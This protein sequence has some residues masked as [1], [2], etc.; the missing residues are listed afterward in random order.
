M[1]RSLEGVLALN[2]CF[3]VSGLA[4]LWAIRGW[5]SWLELL[6]LLGVAFLL[7][8]GSIAVLATLVLVA[9]GGLSLAVIL[10]LCGGVAAICA[11]LAVWRR[12][13]FP[14]SFGALPRSL[15]LGAFLALLAALATAVLLVAF[16]RVTRVQ[17]LTAWD[18][19]AFW[20][21]KAKAIYFFGGLDE[22]LFRSLP[23]PSYPL[24][25]PA[26]DAM[27][28]RLMGGTADTSGL[29]VQYWLLFAG[30]L[31]AA[32]ALLRPLAR[33][34]LVWLFLG[35]ATVIP[36]LDGRLL[37][38]LADWPLDIF[39]VLAALFLVRW[40]RTGEHWLIVGYGVMLAATFATKRE[41]ALLAACLVPAALAAT[42]RDRRRTW[43][44]VLG[45]A[46][47]AYGVN[48][49]WRIWWT[50]RHL[51]PDAPDG[52]LGQLALH[53]S[54]IW[55]SLKLV[56]H[57]LFAYESWLLIV[58]VALAAGVLS[59]LVRGGARETAVLYLLTAVLSVIGFT[60]ILWSDP[61]L[62]LST[63]TAATP[64]PRVVGSL[65]LLSTVLAPLLIDPLLRRPAP[66]LETAV[67]AHFA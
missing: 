47:L 38:G 58:P 27:D 59:L 36:E 19:W 16:F 20:V 5:R 29:A 42:V 61:G 23:G 12:R 63:S 9:G 54:R 33:G 24:L 14:R 17:P 11:E 55:P 35:L 39:F 48:V 30:F 65:V 21:A 15:S 3:L 8:L 51:L 60:W 50:S 31:L 2:L 7:G 56:L 34:W 64:I 26:L 67:G 37:T 6:E 4:I 25:V 40:L 46:V 28:F 49:P 43:L 52:G 13:P 10:G 66:A 53:A 32:A 62:Q 44:P 1:S 22:S 41:G 45:V 57:L 18:A